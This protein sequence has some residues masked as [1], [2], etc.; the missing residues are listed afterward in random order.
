MDIKELK[1]SGFRFKKNLGQNFL[2][3]NNLLRA[4]VKDAGVTSDDVVVEIGAGLGTLTRALAEKAKKVVAFEIDEDLKNALSKVTEEYPSVEIRFED[5]LKLSDEEIKERV[6]EP[7]VVVANLPYY[8]T[9]PMIMKFVEGTLDVTS[10]TLLMQKEVAERLVAKPKTSEYGAIT[11]A[12]KAVADTEIMRIVDRRMFY[13][14]PNVDSALVKST[15]N[16]KKYEFKDYKI[17]KKTV[18]AAFAMRRKTLVNNLISAFSISRENAEKAVASINR[19][20]TVRGEEL[21]CAE[22]VA[23]SDFLSAA[24]ALRTL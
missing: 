18:K 19:E 21:S 3:D 11:A 5:V 24:G 12:I 6:P 1:N 20:K 13:P 16:R 22:L 8:V 4:F 10:M 23:L 9:T 2:T 7:F 14:V 17:F 15:F